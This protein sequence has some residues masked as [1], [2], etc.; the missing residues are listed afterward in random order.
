MDTL[1]PIVT[2]RDAGDTIYASTPMLIT[3]PF[4]EYTVGIYQLNNRRTW[5]ILLLLAM[6]LTPTLIHGYRR[7]F[8][9][10]GQTR[11]LASISGL[12]HER[13]SE[14][15]LVAKPRFLEML[16]AKI[17]KS[18]KTHGA[19]DDAVTALSLQTYQEAFELYI[20][21]CAYYGPLLAKIKWQYETFI[22]QLRQE[23]KRLLPIK[24]V[25]CI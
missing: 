19:T 10:D 12:I 14:L 18:M 17:T 20:Q 21:Q 23:I 9:H 6:A 13:M 3:R 22:D 5:C 8:R 24:V 11:V 2:T 15:P 16:E 1:L 4:I 25:N 7:R